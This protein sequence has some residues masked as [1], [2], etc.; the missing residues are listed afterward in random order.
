MNTLDVLRSIE[1]A[2]VSGNTLCVAGPSGIGKTSISEQY[3]GNKT[4]KP[5]FY[6]V[7]NG[8]TA[9]LADTTGFL[10]PHK[11][12]YTAPDGHEV[13]VPHGHFTYPYFFMDRR[14]KMPAFM[15]DAGLLVIEEY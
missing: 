4:D 13:E 11:V 8:A 14:T 15:F 2:S 3:V 7:F 6:S 9:N 1:L 10:L 5:F 12:K